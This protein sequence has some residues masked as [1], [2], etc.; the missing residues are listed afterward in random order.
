MQR[1]KLA[2]LN[3]NGAELQMQTTCSSLRQSSYL[4]GLHLFQRECE[5]VCVCVCEC[6]CVL[7]QIPESITGMCDSQAS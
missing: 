7:T 3:F 5:C 1:T 6:V 2:L 4:K